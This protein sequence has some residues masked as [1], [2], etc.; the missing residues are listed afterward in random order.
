MDETK[1]QFD[2]VTMVR[3]GLIWSVAIFFSVIAIMLNFRDSEDSTR[4]AVPPAAEATVQSRPFWIYI[5]I[6][7]PEEQ[8]RANRY[9]FSYSDIIQRASYAKLDY[10]LRRLP[11]S[12][13]SSAS[14][15][16]FRVEDEKVLNDESQETAI[17]GNNLSLL[18]VPNSILA[19]YAS[20]HE[21]FSVLLDF[22]RVEN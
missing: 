3:L 16:I 15:K 11:G 2:L 21:A 7:D 13:Y 18:V 9:R 20:Q 8:L 10:E 19:N 12:E 22:V 1:T 5:I 17:S 4:G 6:S 14:C